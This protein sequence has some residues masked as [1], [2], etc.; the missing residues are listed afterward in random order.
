[1]DIEI[2]INNLESR[3]HYEGACKQIRISILMSAKYYDVI[4]NFAGFK[5]TMC[6]AMRK[7]SLNVKP[8]L[9]VIHTRLKLR[10]I[11]MQQAILCKTYYDNHIK[12][13]KCKEHSYMCLK[14]HRFYKTINLKQEYHKCDQLK[15]GN[16]KRYAPIDHDVT[17]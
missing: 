16:C 1:M 14:Y 13:E 8:R 3:Q 5:S 10:A 6:T 11:K 9:N 12:N 15:C 4:S 2:Q 7:Q 17:C